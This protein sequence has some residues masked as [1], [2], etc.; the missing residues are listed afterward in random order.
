[1]TLKMGTMAFAIVLVF[2]ACGPTEAAPEQP[3]AMEVD[4]SLDNA[5]VEGQWFVNVTV[6]GCQTTAYDLPAFDV[7]VESDGDVT[8]TCPECATITAN[9]LTTESV[10]VE[11][12]KQIGDQDNPDWKAIASIDATDDGVT[13]AAS[14]QLAF[15]TTECET[16]DPAATVV[17]VRE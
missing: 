15:A 5:I 7:E 2:T 16:F 4:A 3:D 9:V 12:T 17:R 1:M 8:A 14:V 6:T 11:L 10:H 13:A